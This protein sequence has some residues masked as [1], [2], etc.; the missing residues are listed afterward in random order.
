M[1]V[2]DFNFNYQL[3]NQLFNAGESGKLR[4]TSLLTGRKFYGHLGPNGMSVWKISE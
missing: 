1:D 4:G 2:D 3:G